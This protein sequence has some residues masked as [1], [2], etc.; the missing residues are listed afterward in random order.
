MRD[1]ALTW[2]TTRRDVIFGG[3]SGATA[4]VAADEGGGR[5]AV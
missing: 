4:R 5:A 1:A 3:T 2:F